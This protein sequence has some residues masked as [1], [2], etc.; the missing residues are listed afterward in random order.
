VQSGSNATTTKTYS[1]NDVLTVL[2]PAPANEHNKQ[3]QKEYDGLGRLKSVCGIMVSGG[4]TSCSQATG[5]YSGVF[6]TYAYSAA[7]GSTTTT[8]TRG[9]QTRTTALDAL[10]RATQKTTPEAGTWKSYYDSSTTPACP[11]GYTRAHRDC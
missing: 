1:G 6:T 5:S 10:G 9:S 3:M 2:S 4:Y 7:T 11:S 8:A